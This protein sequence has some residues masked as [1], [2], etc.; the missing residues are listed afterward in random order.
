MF[1]FFF[2]CLL[3]TLRLP[4]I[5]VLSIHTANTKSPMFNAMCKFVTSRS[6]YGLTN[7]AMCFQSLVFR[8][9]GF[10]SRHCSLY[11]KL[12]SFLKIES[13]LA[14]A[15]APALA[16]C[17]ELLLHLASVNAN[18]HCCCSHLKIHTQFRFMAV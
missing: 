1:R 6:F 9:D 3:L 8:I 7:L 11:L 12:W 14:A 5:F 18:Q 2:F 4:I 13:V 15:C 16:F 17:S 10:S